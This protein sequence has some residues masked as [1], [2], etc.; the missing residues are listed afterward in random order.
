MQGRTLI[1]DFLSLRRPQKRERGL[2]RLLSGI[3]QEWFKQENTFFM[4][5]DEY[6]TTG[7]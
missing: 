6:E 2:S 5:E 3:R 7:I 4:K 1:K